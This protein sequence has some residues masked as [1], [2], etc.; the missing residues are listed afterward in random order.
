MPRAMRAD[1]RHNRERLLKIADATF[2]REGVNASLA[3]IARTC[4]IAIGTLYRH[5]PTRDALLQ[6]LIHDQVT[7]LRE[8]A[9]RLAD[10]DTPR[11]ALIEW[12]QEFGRC[13]SAYQGLAESILAAA[14]AEGSDLNA[15]VESMR[16]AAA[17]LLTK[18]QKA[19][20][21]R[22]DVRPA[23]VFALACGAGTASHYAT[24]DPDRLLR[25]VVEGLAPR[26]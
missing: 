9:E 16:A 1:A 8:N 23:E 25:L 18:A 10:S 22:P 17:V 3:E 13:A 20:A 11:E 26:E 15:D 4:G 12:L 6:A 5:F 24:A 2:R 21:I 19:T 7:S 14:A